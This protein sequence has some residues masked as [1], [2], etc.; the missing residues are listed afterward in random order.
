MSA[1]M[2]GGPKKGGDAEHL[3]E[4]R[5]IMM[6]F[7]YALGRGRSGTA[8]TVYLT[9][10]AVARLVEV[11]GDVLVLAAE[12]QRLDA[13]LEGWREATEKSAIELVEESFPLHPGSLAPREITALTVESFLP[14][15]FKRKIPDA[16]R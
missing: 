5:R 7:F 13:V 12:D 10:D 1:V 14:R 2:I 16:P 11:F 15:H 6:E 9:A 4:V 8:R 3:R